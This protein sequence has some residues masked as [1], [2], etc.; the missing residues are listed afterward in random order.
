MNK[1]LVN[2]QLTNALTYT[3]VRR[4]MVMLASNVFNFKNL[5]EYAPNID[6]DYINRKLVYNGAVAWFYDEEL[7]LLAL[8]FNDKGKNKKQ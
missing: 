3:K 6:K 8:P 5:E 4:K 7:G 1:K 2:S